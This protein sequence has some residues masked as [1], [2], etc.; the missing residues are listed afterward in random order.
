MGVASGAIRRARGYTARVKPP[1][2]IKCG[3]LRG[4][5]G[6]SGNCAN[7]RVISLGQKRPSAIRSQRCMAMAIC[8]LI[9]RVL[10][11]D[12]G[13]SPVTSPYIIVCNGQRF[14]ELSLSC[15]SHQ[16]RL[17][18]GVCARGWDQRSQR[19]RMS[20]H[21]STRRASALLAQAKRQRQRSKA[22]RPRAITIASR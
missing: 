12:R 4:L 14:M 5:Y 17:L 8:T 3:N 1:Y 10:Y 20:C 7:G 15:V 18:H 9:S 22:S 2:R 13:G 21:S 19:R 16:T 6:A 11:S